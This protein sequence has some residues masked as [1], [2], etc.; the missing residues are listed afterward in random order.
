MIKTE[1]IESL[2]GYIS[3]VEKNC[4]KENIL[5]RG[6]Q[7]DWPLLPKLARIKLKPDKRLNPTEDEMLKDFERLSLPYVKIVLENNLDK[8][9]LAQHNGMATRLLDWTL[10]PL[11][12]LWFAVC[13]PAAKNEQEKLEDGVVWIYRTSYEDI[14][15][16][17]HLKQYPKGGIYIHRPN[18]VTPQIT[19]Q[20]AL[21]TL[22][23]YNEDVKRFIPMDWLPP[24]CDRLTKLIIPASSFSE[25]RF[26]LDRCGINN[27]TMFPGIGGLCK[28]IEWFHTLLDD[29]AYTEKERGDVPVSE[30]LQWEGA[31]KFPDRFDLRLKNPENLDVDSF[32]Q[33]FEA[34]EK[35]DG[36]WPRHFNTDAGKEFRRWLSDLNTPLQEQAYARLSNWFKTDKEYCRNSPLGQTAKE[37][38]KAMFCAVPERR[39]THPK[40]NY[41][42]LSDEFELWWDK[43]LKC[44]ETR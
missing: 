28:H 18:H 10:N 1:K 42:I 30:G 20:Q 36:V 8:L 22:H 6:Q 34:V 29:E 26:Q 37:F 16:L 24:Y 25:L 14:E 3:F 32:R 35:A 43:Q 23:G 9:A 41:K 15:A 5:F 17:P 7:Q 4:T 13:I 44:Q 2:T 21:F 19:A 27:A 39:L 40:R 12:A 31:S 33:L 38:W 11:A